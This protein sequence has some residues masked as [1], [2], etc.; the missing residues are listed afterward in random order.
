MKRIVLPLVLCTGIISSCQ[1][2]SSPDQVVAQTYVHKYGFDMTER[3]WEER[4]KDGKVVSMLKNGVK[5]TQ[6]FDN[7]HLHGPTTYTFPHSSVVEKV[8]VY[9]QGNILKECINDAHGIPIREE[10]YEFDD[11]TIITLW[12]SKG[13]PLSIEEYDDEFLFEGKYYTPE[14]EL[15]GQVELG[16]GERVKRDRNGTLLT[17]ETVENG[18][19]T[20]RTNYHPNGQI[21]TISHYHDY[22]LHG[23]QHKFTPNG[24]PLM[25]LSW[26]HG[27]LDGKKI[28]YRNGLKVAEI[29]YVNG[30][31]HGTEL[32]YDDLGN[33]IAEIEW[34]NDKKHGFSKTH[35]EEATE[36]EWFFDGIAVNESRYKTLN[37]REQMIAEFNQDAEAAEQAR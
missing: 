4:A 31:K 32:H 15:E 10:A 1:S 33:L 19:I 5:V 7:G 21:H 9:D 24:R 11:R 2:K 18:I 36:I 29:P 8:V 37:E 13:V 3:E 27:V 23:P 34:R 26:N 20:S 28:I 35:T 14:H 22:Q 16:F 25:E 17:R 6:S 12:D 30:N